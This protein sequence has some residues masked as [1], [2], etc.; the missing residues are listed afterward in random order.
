MSLA[1]FYPSKGSESEP[2][3]DIKVNVLF[4]LILVNTTL[5]LYQS[6]FN[7]ESYKCFMLSIKYIIS[8]FYELY[9]DI[10]CTKPLISL[11]MNNTSF[12]GRL[13][14]NIFYSNKF[15]QSFF[16]RLYVWVHLICPTI[17]SNFLFVLQHNKYPIEQ[18]M[19]GI[20]TSLTWLEWFCF[21]LKPIYYWSI[22]V[23]TGGQKWHKKSSHYV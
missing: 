15:C 19:S 1:V 8:Y 9:Y 6:K 17:I 14:S 3:C 21:K 16:H 20:W 5:T 12:K 7:W 11:L 13:L 18:S 22:I 4:Q 23:T 10:V 2:N